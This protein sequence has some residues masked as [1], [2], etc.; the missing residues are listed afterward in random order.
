VSADFFALGAFIHTGV[1]SGWNELERTRLRFRLEEMKSRLPSA[2]KLRNARNLSE[3]A[4]GKRCI[5]TED[6]TNETLASVLWMK[7][8]V[9]PV[10]GYE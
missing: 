10:R 8:W 2:K 7:G 4:D 9:V 3:D 6:A 5:R 1:R